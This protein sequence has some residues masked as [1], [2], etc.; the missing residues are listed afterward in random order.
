MRKW[1]PTLKE[2][3]KLSFSDKKSYALGYLYNTRDSGETFINCKSKLISKK[4]VEGILNILHPDY[5]DLGMTIAIHKNRMQTIIKFIN[6]LYTSINYGTLKGACNRIY[7]ANH[8]RGR[9]D[10]FSYNHE[11]NKYRNKN[12][13]LKLYIINDLLHEVRHAY[14]LKH[15]ESK[16]MNC[17]KNYITGGENGYSEQWIER[18]ANAFATRIMNKHHDKINEIIGI[19]HEWENTWG[20]FRKLFGAETR[21]YKR[22]KSRMT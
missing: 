10:M 14:Q 3:N 19:D 2:F 4:E 1:N 13:S 15:K 22:I 6:P 5:K 17:Q 20:Y 7:A 8:S 18:D 12:I 21:E 9:I 11:V 16:Y